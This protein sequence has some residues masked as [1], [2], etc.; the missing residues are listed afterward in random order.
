MR[1]EGSWHGSSLVSWAVGGSLL[2]SGCNLAPPY[3]RP[4]LE[5]ACQ[6]RFSL[7]EKGCYYEDELYWWK[8]FGDPQLDDYM[9]EA[10]LFNRELKMAAARVAQFYERVLIARSE[11]YPQVDVHGRGLRNELS[12]KTNMLP[13]G[14]ARIFNFF[15]FFFQAAYELDFWG[16]IR[17]QA[18]AAYGDWKASTE[19]RRTVILSLVSSVATSYLFLKQLWAQ[20]AIAQETVASR[21]NSYELAVVRFEEGLSSELVVEQAASEL[22]AS[23]AAVV[24]FEREI[25]LQEDLLSVLL[26][27][28]PTAVERGIALKKLEE[29][30]CLP[31]GLPSSLLGK[32]P[33]LRSAEWA[34]YASGARV[35]EAKAALFPNIR[36]TGLFGYESTQ[37][38]DLFK[39]DSRTWSYGGEFIESLF[40][41]GR[42]LAR[43]GEAHAVRAELYYRYQLAVQ[44]AFAEVEDAL[45]RY[46]KSRELLKVRE[47]GVKA[48]EAYLKLATLQY[49]DGL[50]DYLNVLDAQRELFQGQLAYLDALGESF[51]SIA[52]V[53][54]ALGGSWVCAA[55]KIADLQRY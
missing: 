40:T 41:G 47:K 51:I 33:D 7:E 11:L 22:Y 23:E 10:L 5:M 8:L 27:R 24:E 43:V 38:K 45:I 18:A 35:G 53:Y 16:R 1:D 25:G 54:K 46:K 26:G 37:L 39:P 4:G 19:D 15:T 29:P 12:L 14:A 9:A 48:L 34:L 21:K 55:E 49:E 52:Q 20:H 28:M 31:E 17:N 32:R 13:D 6:W 30:P 44:K 36:L 3:R 2:I 42:L 50:I